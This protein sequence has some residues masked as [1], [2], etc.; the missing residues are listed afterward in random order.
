MGLGEH[1]ND[2]TRQGSDLK[3]FDVFLLTLA[4]LLWAGN[5]VVGRMMTEIC[6]PMTLNFLRWV[7]AF[8]FLL[9]LTYREF[10]LEGPIFRNSKK[11]AVLGF[12]GV[13]S[14]NSLQYLALKTSTPINTTLVASISPV[15]ILLL[16]AVFFHQRIRLAQIAGAILSICGVIVVLCR[17][18]V[19]LLDQVHFV[20]GDAYILLATACWG[21]Y[22]WLLSKDAADPDRVHS[23]STLLM[24]QMV[25]GLMWSGCFTALEWT[26]EEPKLVLG[27]PLAAT[28][29]YLS[30]GPAL[31]AYRCWGLG[32]SRTSPSVA[33]FFSNLTP[34]FAATLSTLALGD[35]PKPFHVLAFLLIV[36]G[37]WISSK[38]FTPKA[39]AES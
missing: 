15:F 16:G 32:I 2:T 28:L 11:F 39:N 33:G 30:I 6:P 20:M 38:K 27:W 37:I 22:S 29:L 12:L 13:G 18:N 17:G 5:A 19:A 9:P 7:F 4:P 35:A 36:S 34:V 8:L 1:Q 31:I 26:L 3:L 25:F 23:W 24:G 10:G 14:Y 21:L